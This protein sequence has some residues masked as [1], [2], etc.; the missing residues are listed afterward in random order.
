MD[1]KEKSL[2]NESLPT[3]EDSQ[4]EPT[5]SQDTEKQENSAQLHFLAA[6]Q[7]QEL[8]AHYQNLEQILRKRTQQRDVYKARYQALATELTKL[9][10]QDQGF[11]QLDDSYLIQQ[12]EGLRVKIWNFGLHHYGGVVS[13]GKS[14]LDP[15]L[16]DYTEFNMRSDMDLEYY[17]ELPD[18]R[19]AI[20][21]AFLWRLMVAEI[22]NRFWWA[23]SVGKS[24]SRLHRVMKQS[25]QSTADIQ[26]FQTWSATTTKLILE[27][28]KRNGPLSSGSPERKLETLV[29]EIHGAIQQYRTSTRGGLMNAIREILNEAIALDEELCQQLAQ[30]EWDFPGPE[31]DYDAQRMQLADGEAPGTDA[32]EKRKICI[33][34][35]WKL[36]VSSGKVVVL[37]DV[38]EKI[39][40]WVDCFVVVGDT[41]IQYDP[42]HAAL[43]WA[44]FCFLLNVA[45]SDVQA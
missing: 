13:R 45:V 33:A 25:F 19:P 30:F 1:A 36:K 6:G 8:Q 28:Q 35:Q 17:L 3:Q 42:I 2:I 22:F 29:K 5:A 44:A 14:L 41:I 32:D 38:L 16:S 7:S 9:K 27:S 34:K 31:V 12:V 21:E 11:S 24:M 37:R 10:S 39:A 43:P 20:M 23:G 26:S 15:L 18:W 4:L 40:G